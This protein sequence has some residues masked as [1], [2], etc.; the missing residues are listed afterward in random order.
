MIRQVETWKAFIVKNQTHY[1]KTNES[2]FN[3]IALTPEERGWTELFQ[4]YPPKTRTGGSGTSPINGRSYSWTYGFLPVGYFGAK[5]QSR[6]FTSSDTWTCP[7]GVNEI[8]VRCIAP[9]GAGGVGYK[10]KGGGGGGFIMAKISTTPGSNYAVSISSGLT[11]FGGVLT[12]TAGNSGANGGTGGNF[13]HTE[14]PTI[15][16]T[17]AGGDGGGDGGSYYYDSGGGG[18]GGSELG[19]G[20]NG[21]YGGGGLHSSKVDKG[22]G[23]MLGAS[24]NAGAGFKS[25]SPSSTG[26][27]MFSST[28]I[29]KTSSPYYDKLSVEITE[30][31]GDWGSPGNYGGGGAKVMF[32][33]AH[34]GTNGKSA[35]TS[36]NATNGKN[37][38][39]GGFGGGGGAG[40][41]GGDGDASINTPQNSSYRLGATGGNGGAG[42]Y[43][44]GGGAGGRGGGSHGSTAGAGGAGSPG[45]AGGGGGGGGS[46]GGIANSGR[47]N[48]GGNGAAGGYGG[49]GGRGGSGSSSGSGGSGGAGIVILEG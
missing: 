35:T 21:R 6:V 8:Y 32:S 30:N 10:Q 24:S 2:K 38:G 37:G 7:D 36:S 16:F 48:N 5:N 17:G 31:L 29:K 43:G 23:G 28:G 11:S 33:G 9:G 4:I 34:A 27:G 13:T 46:T 22:G 26:G 20:G 25:P 39:W 14:T 15:L 47:H 3:L 42:G 49:G 19:K 1:N 18:G 12:A 45:G 41:F 40:G 44:S